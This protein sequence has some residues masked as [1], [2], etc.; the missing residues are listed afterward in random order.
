MRSII[1]GTGG[2]VLAVVLLF[3]VN[4]AG[5]RLLSTARIDL[6]EHRLFTLSEGTRKLLAAIDEPITLRLYVS[7]S[8]AKL[9]PGVHGY[10]T[11]VRSLLDE[12][13]RESNG[14]VSVL[15]ID[16]EPF[17]EEE[18][19]AVGYGLRGLPV[20]TEGDTLY[21][22]LVGSNSTDDEDVIPFLTTDREEFL[23]YDVTKLVHN[24]VN[25][26]QPVVGL[27]SSLPLEGAGPQAA[28]RGLSA[29]PWMVVDQLRQLFEVRAI[30]P[31][32]TSIPEDVDVL[33]VVHPKSLSD[34]LRYAID[35][36]VLRGG[37][38]LVFVDAYAEADQGAPMMPMM[39][40]A[41]ARA[42]QLDD[43]L[44]AW[45][46]VLDSTR[47]V[48][49][50][51]LAV[52]VRAQRNAR[53]ET[54]DYPV[55]L[56][57]GPGQ[58][59]QSEIVTANLGNLSLG[60]SGY[61]E[62]VEGATT[63]VTP[64]LTTTDGAALVDPAM[65]DQNADPQDILR[66]YQPAGR[67]FTLAVRVTGTARSAFPDGPPPAAKKPDGAEDEL[68]D[69]LPG[70]HLAES[71]GDVNL[72]VFADTDLLQDRF[73]VTVQDFLGTRLAVPS[74][75]NGP[76]VINAVDNLEGSNDLISV[77]NRGSFLR[78]FDRID[79]LRQEAELQY[80]EKEQELIARLDE[81]ERRL[82][83]LE[84]RKQGGD[85]LVLSPEQQSELMQFRTERL[86][87]RK[88]LRDVRLQL[89]KS[90]EALETR[91]KVVNIGLVPILIGVVGLL[92]GLWRASRRRAA[93][94]AQV[95]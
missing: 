15:V 88:D 89:R 63:T 41:A 55:W 29:P 61:L 45:G 85:A 49:D 73:W 70:P 42:S 56:N 25:P 21:F 46:L 71:Q 3:A 75:A 82:I 74:A 5:G 72:L 22:G 20:G 50:L 23:E 83:E 35:Q 36:H 60:T 78:P 84:E 6:T 30:E 1:L 28:L 58:M 13:S 92:A 17:S 34:R 2:L 39:N 94:A 38:A 4:I 51:T 53:L 32:A 91:I 14:R 52:K 16:P 62:T 48:A 8:T 19:R 24:L 69:P 90:I 40:M 93:Q 54:F 44:A 31:S 12:Y 66:Q 87:I 10:A 77:R 76:L 79:A 26:Q 43:L 68:A 9:M 33:M 37:H 57:L 18:D 47:V 7:R 81:A 65:L 59:S 27:L 95:G 11:R 64:I 86:R 67:A 80:R